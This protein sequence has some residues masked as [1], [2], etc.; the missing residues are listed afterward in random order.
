[1]RVHVIVPPAPEHE[2]QLRDAVGDFT[3]GPQ[4]PD[5]VDVL[6]HGVP[7]GAQLAQIREGG[8]LVVPYAGLAPAAQRVLETRPDLAVYNLHHNAALV[9]EHAIALLLAASRRLIPAHTALARGDWRPRYAPDPSPTLSGHRALV[10]GYGAIGRRVAGLL[11]GL[12]MQVHAVRRRP[13]PDPRI[14]PLEDLERLLP[15]TR[16]L[17]VA[18]PHTDATD[19]LLS[20]R[21]LAL[22]PP[23]AVL[24]NV[25]RGAIVDEAALHEALEAG[26]L[27]GAGLD[28]WWHYPDADARDDTPPSRLGLHRLDRVV[29]SPHRAGH[30]L[31][32]ETLRTQHLAALLATLAAGGEPDTRVDVAQGY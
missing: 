23:E 9:A 17:I 24:V 11:E 6:V 12:G 22:L 4:L 8:A 10:L 30:A 13:D 29:L 21:R 32:T 1:M 19:G 16:A 15:E 26:R 2:A 3:S 28:V 20:T 18:L 31:Q 27:F 5:V 14:H 7:T 25:G